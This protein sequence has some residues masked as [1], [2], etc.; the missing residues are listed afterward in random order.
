MSI[1]TLKI[2]QLLACYVDSWLGLR[3]DLRDLISLS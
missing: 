3:E 2:E 1:V